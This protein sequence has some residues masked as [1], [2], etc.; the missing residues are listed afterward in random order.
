M[1]SGPVAPTDRL[2]V[3]GLYR[4]VRNPM[5]L[6]VLAAIAGQAVMLGQP[7]LVAYGVVVG[8]AVVSF[9]RGYEEP[10][11]QQRFGPAYDEYRQAVPAWLPRLRPRGRA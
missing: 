8:V 6:A 9:V 3:G 11:L 5:Y 4:F 7:V 2:V 10:T 1:T